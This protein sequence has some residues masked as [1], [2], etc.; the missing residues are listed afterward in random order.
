M[1]PPYDGAMTTTINNLLAKQFSACYDSDS[2]FVS[3][4]NAVRDLNVEQ[5]AWKPID[6]VNCVWE[7]LSHLTYYNAAY[8]QRFKG[9]S[10]EYDVSTNDE[11]FSTGEYDEQSWQADVGRFDSVM[12][13]WRRLIEHADEERFDQPVPNK[14]ERTWA[15]LLADINAH[16]AYH[17]GQIVLLRKMQGSWDD[18]QGVS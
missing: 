3:V 11:T 5:A 18:A 6:G 8:L 13:E 4:R 14:P 12:T 10:H 1:H 2:W 16:N 15:E 17:G 9:E 7:T